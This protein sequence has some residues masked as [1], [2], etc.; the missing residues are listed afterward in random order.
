[1]AE[2]NIVNAIMYHEGQIKV[3]ASDRDLHG[4]RITA[5]EA[6]AETAVAAQTDATAALQ[7][8]QE[9]RTAAVAASAAAAATQT[10]VDT[11]GTAIA[12][13]SKRRRGQRDHCVEPLAGDPGLAAAAARQRDMCG[14][15]EGGG[16][17]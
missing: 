5:L 9:A 7:T 17:E 2:T 3:L 10:T 1:M 4:R 11:L 15:A 13:A 16:R 12:G 14:C 6:R 8:A